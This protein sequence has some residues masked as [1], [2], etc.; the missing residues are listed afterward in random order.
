MPSYK[1]FQL[2]NGQHVAVYRNLRTGGYSIKPSVSGHVLGTTPAIVLADVV[3]HIQR[4]GQAAC[5]KKQVRGVHA[6]ALGTVVSQ[7]L[8]FTCRVR[9]RYHYSQDEFQTENGLSVRRATHCR[10]DETGAYISEEMKRVES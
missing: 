1:K 10:L 6:Y 4:G 3:F 7:E 2:T 5:R 9:V 8:G